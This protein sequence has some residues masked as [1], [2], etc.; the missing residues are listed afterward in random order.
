MGALGRVVVGG[1]TGFVGTQVARTLERKGYEV[2][3][4]S[5]TSPQGETKTLAQTMWPVRVPSDRQE[6]DQ[7]RQRI[8]WSQ[9]EADGLPR[10]TVG[11]VNTAGQNVLDPLRRWGD[12]LKADLYGSR[13]QTNRL[14]AEAVA[15]A[16]SPPLA[17]VS[18]SGVGYYPASKEGDAGHTEASP[19]GEHDWMARLARDWE[20]AGD[21]EQTPAGAA[22]SDT[23]SVQLRSG[24]VLGRHGGLIQQTVLPFYLGLGGRMGAGTQNMPWIHVK[25][26]ADLVVHCLVTPD[27]RG[28]YNAVAPHVVTNNQFVTAYARTMGRPAIFPLPEVVFN[29]IFGRDRASIVTQSQTVLPERTLQSGFQFSY[30]TIETACEECAHL[31]YVDPDM[32]EEGQK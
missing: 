30:P 4:V 14:L 7:A 8:T 28:V 26:L 29:T 25:D 15:K 11:V 13:I 17:F 31:F 1:G 32:L 3:V 19:G 6:Q 2:I 5:R 18:M 21:V 24:V 16:K 9:I 22:G 27:C 20:A 12:K 23:R 10:G